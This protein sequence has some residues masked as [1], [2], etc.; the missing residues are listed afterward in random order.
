VIPDDADGSIFERFGRPWC[1]T[2]QT[3]VEYVEAEDRGH[4][5]IFRV[6]CHGDYTRLEVSAEA[7]LGGERLEFGEVFPKR[8]A[9]PEATA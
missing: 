8:P 1:G 5:A 2:C 3:P 6:H 7:I 9:L 4:V